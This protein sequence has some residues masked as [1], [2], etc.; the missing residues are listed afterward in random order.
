MSKYLTPEEE[1]WIY[2]EE[3]GRELDRMQPDIHEK[4]LNKARRESIQINLR[5]MFR[6]ISKILIGVRVIL[7]GR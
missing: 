6:L 4:M 7:I 5:S 3:Y 2:E 1:Q